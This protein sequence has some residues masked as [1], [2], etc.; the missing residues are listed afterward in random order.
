MKNFLTMAFIAITIVGC[1]SG[2]T[3]N[4]ADGSATQN[5]T[6]VKVSKSNPITAVSVSL[7]DEAKLKQDDNA[8][9]SKDGLLAS[10]KAALV[11]NE[12]FSDQGSNLSLDVVV[13]DFRMRSTFAAMML[14]FLAG[15]DS[16]DANAAIKDKSGVEVDRF[17]VSA[18]YA[19]GG[20][21][22]GIGDVRTG[23][24][25]DSFSN[26]VVKEVS[27]VKAVDQASN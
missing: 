27:G 12:L 17:G 19:M 10:I 20:L 1:A 8:G 5:G 22:G 24:L 25:Y 11:K 13:T 16:I 9:F 4:Q 14:G 15:N 3:R 2:T 23:W 18:S 26:E 21:V 6:Q 7:T